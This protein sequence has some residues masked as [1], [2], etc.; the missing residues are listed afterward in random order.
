[1]ISTYI[2]QW[3][4][5]IVIYLIIG[6]G[7]EQEYAKRTGKDHLETSHI[8]Y[9]WILLLGA[10]VVESIIRGFRHTFRMDNK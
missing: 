1:M 10:W 3:V 9:A 6:Y 7:A 5:G 4:I 2:I 8:T